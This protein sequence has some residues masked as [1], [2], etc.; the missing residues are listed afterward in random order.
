MAHVEST[1]V[2]ISPEELRDRLM[3]NESHGELFPG[4]L[5]SDMKP[6]GFYFTDEGSVRISLHAPE[7]DEG[8]DAPS[9]S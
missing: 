8:G 2:V 1:Y 5:Q 7:L 6:V 4:A 3:Y 9:G